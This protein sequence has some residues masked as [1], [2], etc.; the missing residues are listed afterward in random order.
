MCDAR[1][2]PLQGRSEWPSPADRDR[3][4]AALQRVLATRDAVTASSRP[5][6]IHV[7]AYEAA[8]AE[9]WQL[10]QIFRVGEDA[11]SGR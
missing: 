6:E 4:Q 9:A 11:R 1:L 3:Y 5:T 8:V 2:E 7:A 10:H